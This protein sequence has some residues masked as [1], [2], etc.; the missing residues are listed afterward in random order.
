LVLNYLILNFFGCKIT[1]RQPKSQIYLRKSVERP[2]FLAVSGK[3]ASST[4]GQS[5]VIAACSQYPEGTV[6]QEMAIS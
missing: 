4:L 2:D 5:G 1:A 3:A 6:L